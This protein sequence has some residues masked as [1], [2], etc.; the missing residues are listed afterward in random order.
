MRRCIYCHVPQG[1]L[2]AAICPTIT[3]PHLARNCYGADPQALG[4]LNPTAA[5][6]TPT[7]AAASIVTRYEFRADLT[8][9]LAEHGV[10]RLTGV[11]PSTLAQLLVGVLSTLEDIEADRQ[12]GR[13]VRV[14][15]FPPISPSEC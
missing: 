6:I 4:A 1:Q 11:R 10:H 9:M 7:P 13:E 14:P 15:P 12:R 3:Y 8:R 5:P 2:H